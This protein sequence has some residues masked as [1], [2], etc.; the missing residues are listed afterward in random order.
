MSKNDEEYYFNSLV[1]TFKRI[2]NKRLEDSS[3]Y[4]TNIKYLKSSKEINS[5]KVNDVL[6]IVLRI[7]KS[8]S[9]YFNDKEINTIEDLKSTQLQLR[10]LS[11]LFQDDIFYLSGFMSNLLSSLDYRNISET[12]KVLKRTYYDVDYEKDL[13]KL[14]KLEAV[15]NKDFLKK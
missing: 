5:D 6:K 12:E 13:K 7:G 11:D 9:D 1:E 2:K 4:A 3:A 10:M 14:E 8:V 15:L